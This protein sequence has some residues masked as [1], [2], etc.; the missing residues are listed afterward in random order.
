METVPSET[1]GDKTEWHRITLFGK[2]AE[3]L[4]S[5]LKKGSRIYVEGRLETS[6][7]DKDGQKHFSTNIIADQIRFGGSK[8]NGA[9][10]TPPPASQASINAPPF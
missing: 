3:K 7:Y 10:T 6:S 8:S 1:G 4:A 2:G 5:S 9:Y